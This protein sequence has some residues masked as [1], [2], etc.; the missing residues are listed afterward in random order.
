MMVLMV[1]HQGMNLKSLVDLSLIIETMIA[2]LTT[3]APD[4]LPNSY[5]EAAVKFTHIFAQ[6]VQFVTESSSPHVAAWA[7]AYGTGSPACAGVSIT[8]RAAMLKVSPQALSKQI[9]AFVD[10]ADLS[11]RTGYLYSKQS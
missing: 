3:T 5:R 1:L 10:E 7:V 11:D 9:R 6:S 2:D 8:D 4:S